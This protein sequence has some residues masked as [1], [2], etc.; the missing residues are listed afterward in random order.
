[1]S[2]RRW[3]WL[4]V[5]AALTGL[6]L[7]TGNLRALFAEAIGQVS[8]L[9]VAA[10]L[11]GQIAAALLCAAALHALR[12][13]PGL[14]ACLASRLLRD[15]GDNLLVLFPGLGEAI[16]ARALVLAGGRSHAAISASALDKLAETLAQVPYIALAVFVLWQGWDP[17][18][19]SL[20]AAAGD[21]GSAARLVACPGLAEGR[22]RARRETARPVA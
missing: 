13:G 8:L 5:L 11:P 22:E 21:P 2:G 4:P 14:R 12:P 15:A 3:L 1:M 7:A 16:G 10:T 19:G 18:I 17:H 20:A 9:A 6:V